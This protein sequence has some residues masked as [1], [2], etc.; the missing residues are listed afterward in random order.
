MEIKAIAS[1][2]L[3]NEEHYKYQSDFVALVEEFTPAFLGVEKWYNRYRPLWQK[4]GDALEYIRKSALTETIEG[5]DFKRDMTQKGMYGV[6]ENAGQHFKP[7]MREAA[8][9]LQVVLDHYGDMTSLPY[10]KETATIK[11]FI[12]EIRTNHAADATL[13]GLDEWLTELEADNNAFDALVTDRFNETD[14]KTIGNVKEIRQA[15]DDANRDIV[16]R[17][18]ARI[19][20]DEEKDYSPFVSKLNLRIEACNTTI[21]LRKGRA[22]AAKAEAAAKAAAN[23]QK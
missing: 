3:Q 20:V 2:N 17:I 16:T 8:S 11:S 9:R 21:A 14:H 12:K 15:V 4:E 19:L 6:V 10:E 13:V 22:A 7:E 23:D 1:K 18:N 5:A